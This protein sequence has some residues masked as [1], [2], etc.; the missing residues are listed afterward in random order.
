[1]IREIDDNLLTKLENLL[2][3]TPTVER[4]KMTKTSKIVND[5]AVNDATIQIVKFYP[6]DN[7]ELN[8]LLS[9]IINIDSNTPL[10]IHDVTYTVGGMAPYHKDKDSHETYVIMLEDNF[11]GGD[12]YL[13]GE[14]TN[15]KKRG[16]IIKYVGCHEPHSVSTITRGRRRVLVMWYTKPPSSLI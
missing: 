9:H 1:M 13:N 11:E 10:T 12:F 3:N 2:I 15:F 8:K 6:V 16:Q 4:D 7:N 5:Y 14:L